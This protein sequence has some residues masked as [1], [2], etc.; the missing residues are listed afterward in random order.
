[1]ADAKTNLSHSPT[2]S[3]IGRNGEE[4]SKVQSGWVASRTLLWKREKTEK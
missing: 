1:M 3:Q 4:M 2:P